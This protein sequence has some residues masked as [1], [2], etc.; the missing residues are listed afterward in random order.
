MKCALNGYHIHRLNSKDFITLNAFT[1]PVNGAQMPAAWRTAR[2]AA[3]SALVGNNS[4][5][6]PYQR[7]EEMQY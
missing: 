1:S 7:Q 6:P 4:T 5:T 3:Q 2:G